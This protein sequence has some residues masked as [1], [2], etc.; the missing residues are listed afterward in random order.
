MVVI[1]VIHSLEDHGPWAGDNGCMVKT[2]AL[3]FP[4]GQLRYSNNNL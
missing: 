2:S 4:S 1:H 3:I